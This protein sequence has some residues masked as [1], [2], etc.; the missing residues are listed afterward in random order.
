MKSEEER[1]ERGGKRRGKGKREREKRGVFSAFLHIFY[2]ELLKKFRGGFAPAPRPGGYRPLD[3]Q[4]WGGFAPPDPPGALGASPLGLP[5]VPPSTGN[6]G[7]RP[8]RGLFFPGERRPC[9][10]RPACRLV[11]GRAGSAAAPDSRGVSGGGRRRRGQPPGGVSRPAGAAG[12]PPRRLAGP[13]LAGRQSAAGR[14]T[15]RRR[16]APAD[17][18]SR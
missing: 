8:L 7:Q 11:L 18:E 15:A 12:P 6:P 1:G 16:A 9:W 13:P 10:R 17:G 14:G 2:V 4:C 5:R 3:P